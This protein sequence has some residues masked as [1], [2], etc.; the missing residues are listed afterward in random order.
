MSLT[1]WELWACANH[2]HMTHGDGAQAYIEDQI[3]V[4]EARDDEA[5]MSTWQEIGRRIVFL[6]AGE[7]APGTRH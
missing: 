4:L 1:D 7:Q 3:A 2:V 6:A 5:G